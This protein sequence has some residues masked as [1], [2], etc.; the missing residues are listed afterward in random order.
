ML[1]FLGVK[2]I[3]STIIHPLSEKLNWRLCAIFLFLRHVKIIN[4]NNNLIFALFRPEESFSSSSTYLWVNQSLDL[5]CICLS[6]KS[7]GQE[8]V[9]KIVI[10]KVELIC[11]IDWFTSTC[12]PAEKHMH[13]IFNVEIQEVIVSNWVVGRNDKFIVWNVLGN[14]KRCNCLWPILPD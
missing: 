12:G 6:W 4:E 2:I 8:S 3:P 5:I 11:N 9:F 10:I 7:S 14:H 13:M 1:K